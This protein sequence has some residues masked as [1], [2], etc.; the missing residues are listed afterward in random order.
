MGHHPLK[1]FTEGV[2]RLEEILG[3]KPKP[4]YA[5]KGVFVRDRGSTGAVGGRQG[6]PVDSCTVGRRVPGRVRL[7]DCWFIDTYFGLW[8]KY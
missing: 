1:A 6:P 2:G 4:L 5:L 8:T 3:M 7:H